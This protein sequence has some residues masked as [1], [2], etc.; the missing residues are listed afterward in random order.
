MRKEDGGI[1]VLMRRLLAC[2]ICFV[3]ALILP[4]IVA[5]EIEPLQIAA[6]IKWSPDGAMLL[7]SGRGEPEKYGVW[8][9]DASLNPLHFFPMTDYIYADWKPDSTQFFMGKDVF[10]AK[11]FEVVLSLE[12]NISRWNQE[13]SEIFTVLNAHWLGIFDAKSG[14]LVRQVPIGEMLPDGLSWSPNGEYLLFVQPVGR[15]EIRSALNGELLT[16]LEGDF[17]NGL[18]WSPDSRYLAGSTV[19]IVEPGT[20]NILPNAPSPTLASMKIWDVTTG[21]IVQNFSGLVAPPTLL[22]W[23]P[24]KPEL[25]AASVLGVIYIWNLET[26]EQLHAFTALDSLRGIAYSP[27]GGRLVIGANS[28]RQ[29]MSEEQRQLYP[30]ETYWTQNIVENALQV[31]VL[32]PSPEKLREIEAFCRSTEDESRLPDGTTSLSAYTEAVHADE[33]LPSGCVADLVAVAEA[34]QEEQ[35][36]P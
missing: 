9:Y 11:T 1:G 10:D 24:Y 28:L 2:V 21:K 3:M 27:F 33:M 25:A 13:E 29:N 30:Q 34:L 4:R 6:Y 35:E 32:D 19:E 26:G 36:K 12:G 16:T 8:L 22:L 17:A 31:I 5:Q 7:V 14:E 15:L 18:I 23:H 20:P